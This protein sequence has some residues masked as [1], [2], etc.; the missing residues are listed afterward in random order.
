MNEKTLGRMITWVAAL[1]VA[2]ISEFFPMVG[3]LAAALVFPEGIE[4]GHGT[5]YLALAMVLNF[6]LYFTITSFLIRYLRRRFE[7]SKVAS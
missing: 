6:A 3:L 7:S 4:S 2:A 1:S 5:A